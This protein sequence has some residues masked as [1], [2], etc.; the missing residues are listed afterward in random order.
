MMHAKTMLVD[1]WLSMVGS[2]N[3]DSLSLNKLGE[4]S[5]VL[6]DEEFDRKLERCWHRDLEY[7]REITLDTGGRTNP[8]RR[9]ARRV[10][11]LM[12]QD[13]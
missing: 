11:Q 1:D 7:S 10:T 13:R 9:L 4:G 6:A 8:W 3:M 2:T 5:V 12:G